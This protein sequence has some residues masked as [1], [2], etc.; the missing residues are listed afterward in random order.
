MMSSIVSFRGRVYGGLPNGRQYELSA[1]QKPRSSTSPLRAVHIAAKVFFGMTIMV[2]TIL[3]AVAFS[4]AYEVV[5]I[6]F[7]AAVI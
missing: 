1:S 3:T 7:I 4:L 2:V 5:P 6:L